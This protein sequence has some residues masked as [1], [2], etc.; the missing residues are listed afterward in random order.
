MGLFHKEIGAH[1]HNKRIELNESLENMAHNLEISTTRMKDIENGDSELSWEEL[2]ALR[3]HYDFDV[4]RMF[5]S[6]SEEANREALERCL[7]ETM[8]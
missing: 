6:L 1:L 7:K 3:Y 8:G 5:D 4:N 2:K